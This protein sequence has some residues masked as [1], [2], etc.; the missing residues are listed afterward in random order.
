[1]TPDEI[2][3]FITEDPDILNEIGFPDEKP[4]NIKKD[5]T[6]TGHWP[7]KFPETE[8]IRLSGKD[9]LKDLIKAIITSLKRIGIEVPGPLVSME[10]VSKVA[11]NAGK[12][13]FEIVKIKKTK[14]GLTHQDIDKALEIG[15]R[16]AIM[17]SNLAQFYDV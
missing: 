17:Q 2:A 9:L 16:Q 14:A 5:L 6:S 10:E 12:A 7:P 15:L 1:M 13:A 11:L 8:G 4:E 3:K